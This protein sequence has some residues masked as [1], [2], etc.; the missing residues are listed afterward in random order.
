MNEDAVV[1]V[2]GA[3]QRVRWIR[4]GLPIVVRFGR[5]GEQHAVVVDPRVRTRAGR[6]GLRVMKWRATTKRWTGTVVVGLADI[7][8]WGDAPVRRPSCPPGVT[9]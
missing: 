7:L 1:P 6:D 5:R 2:R 3:D 9:P 8:D 4:R